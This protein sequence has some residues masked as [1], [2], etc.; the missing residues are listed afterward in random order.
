[1]SPLITLKMYDDNDLD[2]IRLPYD[3]VKYVIGKEGI[4]IRALQSKTN[5]MLKKYVFRENGQESSFLLI[6]GD[7]PERMNAKTAILR[8][9]F[10]NNEDKCRVCQFYEQGEGRSGYQCRFYHDTSSNKSKKPRNY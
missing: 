5:T 6:K 4:T 1:M 10:E 9:I 7:R 3:K 8:V 2:V